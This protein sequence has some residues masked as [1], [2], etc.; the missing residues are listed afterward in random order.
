MNPKITPG[1]FTPIDIKKEGALQVET[2]IVSPH[3]HHIAS[4]ESGITQAYSSSIV[5]ERALY[6]DKMVPNLLNKEGFNKKAEEELKGYDGH[7]AIIYFDGDNFKNI[8]DSHGHAVGDEVIIAMGNSMATAVESA[9]RI[10]H[11]TDKNLDENIQ[12]KKKDSGCD[13]DLLCRRGGDEFCALLLP[14]DKE[15]W[16]EEEAERAAIR[17]ID[18]INKKLANG[19]PVTDRHGNKITIETS[20]TAGEF[21]GKGANKDMTLGKMTDMA[22]KKMEANKKARGT[23]RK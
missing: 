2:T 17:Y 11:V 14:R 3:H 20:M 22:D 13:R 9:S 23:S 8:N 19:T 5:L 10:G 12:K 15:A 18:R 16:T 4:M 1:A 6:Y 7:F 21:I